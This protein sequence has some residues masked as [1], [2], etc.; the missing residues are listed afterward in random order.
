MILFLIILNIE[1]PPGT[2][3][4]QPFFGDLT[5]PTFASLWD[6]TKAFPVGNEDLFSSLGTGL[7]SRFS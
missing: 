6:G 5:N 1:V 4:V 2:L 7:S 3:N